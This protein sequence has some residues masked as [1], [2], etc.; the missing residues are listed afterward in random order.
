MTCLSPPTLPFH[1]PPLVDCRV[2]PP[3][4]PARRR[5]HRDNA[6]APTNAPPPTPHKHHPAKVPTPTPTPTLPPIPPPTHYP[7]HLAN[8][9]EREPSDASEA[10]AAAPPPTSPWTASEV[11][12]MTRA[13][14]TP[15]PPS[16][17]PCW[18]TS[19]RCKL[20]RTAVA[21]SVPL[22]GSSRG[23]TKHLCSGTS[24]ACRRMCRV[25]IWR[26]GC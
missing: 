19:R 20:N 15:P 1:L 6:P 23:L 21:S 24:I 8:A 13:P 22:A 16:P 10:C 17:P 14:L 26:T 5:Q 4:T 7:Q 3:P 11:S 2:P 12:Q 18:R 9:D 25:M